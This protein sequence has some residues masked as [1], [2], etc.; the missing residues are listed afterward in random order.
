MDQHQSNHYHP[1]HLQTDD[2]DFHTVSYGIFQKVPSVK[3]YWHREFT[4]HQCDSSVWQPAYDCSKEKT[5]SC[6]EVEVYRQLVI[7]RNKF[8]QNRNGM[9]HNPDK[10]PNQYISC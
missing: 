2:P 8:C 7:S 10:T 6:Q 3:P 5:G 4:F 1:A 9:K